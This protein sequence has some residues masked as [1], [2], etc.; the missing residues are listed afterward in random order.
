MGLLW[1]ERAAPAPPTPPTELG[2][3]GA[4]LNMATVHGVVF[5]NDKNAGR[6]ATGLPA[7]SSF[8]KL[9][10]TVA[11][12]RGLF[13]WQISRSS[14]RTASFAAFAL[15]DPPG[16][17]RRCV[18][19]GSPVRINLSEAGTKS[20]RYDCSGNRAHP[21]PRRD[22][23]TK[24]LLHLHA[25]ALF[26]AC[27]FSVREGTSTGLLRSLS[28][29]DPKLLKRQAARCRRL[30]SGMDDRTVQALLH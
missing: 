10:H 13:V 26:Y 16:G 14:A 8:A 29:T 20:S 18:P 30:A 4:G 21:S 1:E 28:M 15:C 2:S 5:A 6:S 7:S 23:M 9:S 17:G 25:G 19:S 11:G 24:G 12:A 3:H 22:A 27:V